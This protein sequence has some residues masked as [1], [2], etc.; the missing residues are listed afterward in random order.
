ML[1]EET[2]MKAEKYVLSALCV[3]VCIWSATMVAGVV[4]LARTQGLSALFAL[5]EVATFVGAGLV[6]LVLI[7][8][9]GSWK[10]ALIGVWV[11]CISYVTVLALNCLRLDLVAKGTMRLALWMVIAVL[12]IRALRQAPKHA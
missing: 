9:S 1:G 7:W 2:K 4:G 6:P 12:F 11:V 10:K 3:G 8:T 5:F